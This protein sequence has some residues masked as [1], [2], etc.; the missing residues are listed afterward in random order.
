MGTTKDVGI[1]EGMP[2]ILSNILSIHNSNPKKCIQRFKIKTT[3]ESSSAG[4][5]IGLWNA[6]G[7]SGPNEVTGRGAATLAEAINISN[8]TK[9]NKKDKKIILTHGIIDEYTE[10]FG[11]TNLESEIMNSSDS[12]PQNCV[13]DPNVNI[14]IKGSIT[15]SNDYVGKLNIITKNT[16]PKTD[17]SGGQ[18][19]I[20]MSGNS[21]DLEKLNSAGPLIPTYVNWNNQ[22]GNTHLLSNGIESVSINAGNSLVYNTAA[23]TSINKFTIDVADKATVDQAIKISNSTNYIKQTTYNGPKYVNFTTGISDK[24]KNYYVGETVSA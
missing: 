6:E 23:S 7:K 22:N 20:N 18:V 21:A 8:A 1:I 9:Y 11:K 3:A 15:M 14:K 4:R 24:F 5:A 19:V 16:E 2:S 13:K 10:Y 12:S 17:G